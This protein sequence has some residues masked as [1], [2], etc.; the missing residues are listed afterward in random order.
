MRFFLLTFSLLLFLRLSAQ[1]SLITQLGVEQGLS[2]NH[3]VSITQDREGFLWFATEEGL[4]RFDGLR[5]T[6]YYK[7]NNEISGNELNYVLADHQDPVIWIATQRDGLNALNYA[8]DSL[9]VYRH[10]EGDKFSLITND[11]TSIAH[12]SDG[13]LWLSTYHRGVEYFDKQNKTFTHYN[14]STLS[15]LPSDKVWSVLD[16]QQGHLFIG[17]VSDGLSVLSLGSNSVK[18]FRHNPAESGSIP[19]NEVRRIYKDSHQNIWVGTDKG[20]ALFNTEKGIFIKPDASPESPLNSAIFDILQTE[21]NKLWIA[22]ELNGVY[23]LDLREHFFSTSSQLNIQHYTVGYSRNS[24]SNPTVRCIFQD[25]FHNIWMGTYGGGVNF[26]GHEAPLFN[27]YSYSPISDDPYGVNNRMA[28]S[29]ALDNENKLW[30]GTDGGGINVF[31]NEKRVHL[32]T[33]ES[34]DLTHNTIQALLKD[35]DHNIWIGSFMGGVN[36]FD[37]QSKKIVSFPLDGKVNQDIRCFY[38]DEDN[39]IWVGSSSGVYLLNMKEKRQIAHYTFNDNGLPEDLVRSIIQD[40]QGR[41]W[42][43]TFGRGLAVFTPDM[44]PLAYF[45]EENGFISNTINHLFVDSQDRIWV[46]TGEGL[47]CFTDEDSFNYHCFG[48]EEGLT[49][50]YIRAI[51]EDQ[52]KNIWFSTNKGISCYHPQSGTFQHY[53]HEGKTPM[54]SFLNAVVRDSMNEVV[55]FASVNG[56][57]FFKPFSVLQEQH[58]PPAIVTE[59]RVYEPGTS[60]GEEELL[61]Y[62]KGDNSAIRL[63]HNQNSFT[64][65]YCVQDYALI[66]RVGYLYRLKGLD[67]TWQE[68]EENSVTFRNIPPGHYQF[69]VSSRMKNQLLSDDVYSIS[70]RIVPPLWLT[71]WAKGI[72]IVLI[73]SILVSILYFYKKRVDIQSFYEIEKKKL[74]QEQELNDERLRFYTNITHELRTPLTLI[75]GPLDDLQNDP[76]LPAPQLHKIALVRKSALRLLNLI[77]QLLE[78]RKTETHNKKLC[79]AKGNIAALVKEVG[80]KYKELNI[81]QNVEI[82]IELESEEMMLFYDRE[83]VNTILD[84]LMSNAVKYTNSGKISLSLFT[85]CKNDVSYTEMKVEDTGV[86]IPEEELDRIFERYYQVRNKKQASGTG[87]GLALIKKLAELHE[88]EINVVSEINR[89]SSFSFTILT[90][91]SYPDALHADYDEVSM[92]ENGNVVEIESDEERSNNGKPVLL[93]VEDNNEIRDY[94][95]E[96]LSDRF[97]V[98]TAIEGEEGCKVAFSRIPDIIISDIMMPG[99]DGISFC[100][101]VKEDIRTS[102]IP[103][104]LLTAKGSLR[105]KEEGYISGADS[106]LT[107]PFSARLL[108]SRIDNLLDNRRKLAEQFKLQL[109]LDSKSV[110]LNQSLSQLDR[111]FIV[112]V[113]QLIEDNLEQEKI[114]VGFLSD[115]LSMSSS[116]LYR[117]IKALTGIST[118][119][120]IRKIR[121]KRA[122]Q[123]LLTGKYTVSEVGYQVGMNSPI[124]FRQCFKE[125]FGMAPSDYL[126]KIKDGVMA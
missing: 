11:I 25:S 64:I 14:S 85:F 113:T 62:F 43:G 38:E 39:N 24:L 94:I 105:D 100:K 37:H 92:L 99:M 96:S 17:H 20:L 55:Y 52:E 117:K 56:V 32:F 29:L 59:I 34:G 7:H 68:V 40:K 21:D 3:V 57:Y 69:Q 33:K 48:R 82:V 45:N 6:N 10:I 124:Y 119:E 22:T 126:R 12:A 77:N 60:L 1:P 30:I 116:T 54:S 112:N 72:Y 79:V 2:D 91:N 67:D 115:A 84:N 120:F 108:R 71:W 51:T 111:E 121:M 26:I 4:N 104:I 66:D 78:F 49:N 88:G 103:L 65:S 46:A 106:Y 93:V 95:S 125:E 102:H 16:D 97:E 123:L 76:Q 110:L 73:A 36:Y 107:K 18:N 122:E 89:G 8:V 118:N 58:I 5:F 35:S 98:M 47:T 19:G 23:V 15:G 109:K 101:K 86:G 50:T 114:D 9:E 83:V 53:G 61:N 90:Q 70:I 31:E 81:K 87:I 74:A 63:N 27:K 42:I 75:I 13:N 28:L 41:M 80:L 44:K